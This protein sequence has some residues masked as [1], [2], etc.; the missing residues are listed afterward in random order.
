M[1][2]TYLR[3]LTINC[4]HQDNPEVDVESAESIAS[5]IF[6]HHGRLLS[7]GLSLSTIPT[8]QQA[9]DG[10]LPY[11]YVVKIFC[12]LYFLNLKFSIKFISHLHFIF[13]CAF[14]RTIIFTRLR[15]LCGRFMWW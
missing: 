2:V 13:Q 15:E 11:R 12:G 14:K 9:L 10:I 8:V 4:F 1:N 6:S 3:S 7:K 5:E